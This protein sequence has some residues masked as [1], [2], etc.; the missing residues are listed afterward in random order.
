LRLF[1]YLITDSSP[2]KCP[3]Y[4]AAGATPS[5]SLDETSEKSRGSIRTEVCFLVQLHF[6]FLL[7]FTTS[8]VKPNEYSLAILCLTICGS[9]SCKMLVL[10]AALGEDRNDKQ[11]KCKL[12]NFAP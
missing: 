3:G 4:V 8:G 9:V 6:P 5:F 7:L 11:I 10:K 2:E 12:S 1:A